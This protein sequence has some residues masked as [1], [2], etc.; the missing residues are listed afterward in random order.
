M[1]SSKPCRDVHV[2]AAKSSQHTDDKNYDAVRLAEAAALLFPI[3]LP[4]PFGLV[5]TS[6]WRAGHP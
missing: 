4:E 5:M 2:A 1:R 3:D 6:Q